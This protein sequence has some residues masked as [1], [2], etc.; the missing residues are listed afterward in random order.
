MPAAPRKPVQEIQLVD[1]VARLEKFRSGRVALHLHLSNL[2]P[3]YQRENYLRIAIDSFSQKI[4]NFEG[5]LF[6]L[7]NG[8]LFFIAKDVS[9]EQLNAAV[10][11]LRGL[12][13]EDPIVQFRQA[14]GGKDF[15][16]WY[17]VEAEYEK[18]Y[19]KVRAILVA[20]ELTY[21]LPEHT[22]QAEKGKSLTAIQPEMLAKLERLLEKADV[23][24]IAKK[25]VACT[26]IEGKAPIPLFEE[27]FVSIED[28][29]AA[30]TPGVDLLGNRWLFQYLTQ[31]LDRRIMTMLTRDNA[32]PNRPFS[33][34]LNVASVLSPEFSRFEQSLSPQMRGRLVIEMNKID[35]FADMGAFCF[36]RDYLRELGF[37]ICLDGLT[38]HTVA[39]YDRAKLGFDLVKLYW[40]PDSIDNMRPELIPG[41]RGIIMETG[42]ARTILC[43]CDSAR[44]IEIGQELG[45][46]MFQGRHVDHIYNEWRKNDQK[47]KETQIV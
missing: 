43:R 25:Q 33:L 42:Q 24:S 4:R 44:A 35:V 15:C 13:G 41:V 28:L 16:T 26:L 32:A 47:N 20:A 14:D 3:S 27:I 38:H 11:R 19:Q 31:T 34:N 29:Q 6:Q 46:I 12:F 10:D 1:L 23:S 45:I 37:R 30:A 18:L 8:D 40:T 39:Y 7:Y 5:Q 2:L 21:S 9:L 22:A 17:K 36:A